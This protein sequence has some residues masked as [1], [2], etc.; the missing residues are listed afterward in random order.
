[1]PSKTHFW[2][3][4]TNAQN[5]GVLVHEAEIQRRSDADP[6][7]A[8]RLEHQLRHDLTEPAPHRRIVALNPIPIDQ[9]YLITLNRI[10]QPSSPMSPT[11]ECRCP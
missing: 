9:Q 4:S 3:R 7:E 6:L 11:L 10:L 1:M 2:T 8:D 5:A